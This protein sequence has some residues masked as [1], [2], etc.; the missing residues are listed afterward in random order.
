MVCNDYQY[1]ARDKGEIGWFTAPFVPLFIVGGAIIFLAIV[2]WPYLVKGD[3]F[4]IVSTI[5]FLLLWAYSLICWFSAALIDPGE[6]PH[7]NR[8]HQHSHNNN[9]SNNNSNTF[10]TKNNLN[11]DNNGNDDHV[12]I[13]FKNESR[14]SKEE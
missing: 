4:S 2:Q 3:A 11:A 7:E 12:I 14:D 8:L 5:I 10:N 1:Y 9:N 6:G 13:E